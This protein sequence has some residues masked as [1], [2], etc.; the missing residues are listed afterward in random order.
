MTT[1]DTNPEESGPATKKAAKKAAPEARNI[2]V[3]VIVPGT[4][5]GRAIC[6]KGPCSIPLT[7][8]EAEALEALGKVRIRGIF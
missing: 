8:S 1:E 6:G 7:P 4:K 3:E 2:A 5:I